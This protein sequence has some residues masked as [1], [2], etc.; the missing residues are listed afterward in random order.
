MQRLNKEYFAFIERTG[1]EACLR[2]HRVQCTC[3]MAR[4]SKRLVG[5]GI[6]QERILKE[7]RVSSRFN[8]SLLAGL[9]V[10]DVHGAQL[11]EA[12]YGRREVLEGLEQR[13]DLVAPQMDVA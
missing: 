3:I 1:G 12:V 13:H 8:H 6:G 2:I 4:N 7:E 9:W 5:D 11:G 10:G